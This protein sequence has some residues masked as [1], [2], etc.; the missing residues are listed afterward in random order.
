METRNKWRVLI[1]HRQS[2][3]YLQRK[4]IHKPEA[5]H[6][7]YVYAQSVIVRVCNRTLRTRDGWYKHRNNVH[8]Q[9]TTTDASEQPGS[10]TKINDT[11]L[12]TTPEQ[13]FDVK[14]NDWK[15]KS[16]QY[17]TLVHEFLHYGYRD[18]VRLQLERSNKSGT[19]ENMLSTIITQ[20]I[21]EAIRETAEQFSM[22][23]RVQLSNIT[24]PDRFKL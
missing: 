9:F 18:A 13:I 12:A 15:V 19:S 3:I 4:S 10:S 8:K 20:H 22:Y 23:M 17:K 1:H 5:E 2:L 11:P 24:V 16:G 7:T 21:H 14:Y 6:H